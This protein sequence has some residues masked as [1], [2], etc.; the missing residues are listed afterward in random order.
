MVSYGAGLW[1]FSPNFFMRRLETV[2]ETIAVPLK[3]KIA[4][5]SCTTSLANALLSHS[6]VF[7]GHNLLWTTRLFPVMKRATSIGFHNNIV[8][9]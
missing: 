8:H 7:P 4:L 1:D 2:L 6:A 3:H 5:F 9:R